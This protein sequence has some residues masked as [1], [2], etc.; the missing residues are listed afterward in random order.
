[1]NEN[2]EQYKRI[3]KRDPLIGENNKASY[4]NINKGNSNEYVNKL[5]EIY[6]EN[7]DKENEL[8]KYLFL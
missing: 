3:E 2:I 1:M 7:R 8:E 4:T 5:K 6:Q